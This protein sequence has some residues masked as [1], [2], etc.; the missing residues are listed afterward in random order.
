MADTSSNR[1]S[2]APIAEDDPFAELTRIMGFDPRVKVH[3]PQQPVEPDFGL[4]LERELLGE[5]HGDQDNEPASM[6][7][8]A[9]EAP[10]Q[11]PVFAQS[12]AAAPAVEPADDLQDHAS[13]AAIQAYQTDDETVDFRQAAD[14]FVAEPEQ[15]AVEPDVDPFADFELSFDE[16]ETIST[17]DMLHQ[18]SEP[19]PVEAVEVSA[20]SQAPAEEDDEIEAAYAALQAWQ[21]D[22]DQQ[23]ADHSQAESIESEAVESE[24]EAVSVAEPQLEAV[25]D[26]QAVEPVAD[27]PAEAF[28]SLDLQ[29]A[30]ELAR[31]AD[32]PGS[33]D[34]ASFEDEPSAA[35]TQPALI[36]EH[37]AGVVE[38]QSESDPLGDF[39]LNGWD[40]AQ[41]DASP[42]RDVFTAEEGWLDE[43]SVALDEPQVLAQND[44]DTAPSDAQYAAPQSEQWALVEAE[45]EQEQQATPA[46]DEAFERE[47]F[48]L[49]GGEMDSQQDAQSA[50]APEDD[51]WLEGIDFADADAQDEAQGI[52]A[53]AAQGANAENDDAL[54]HLDFSEV[55]TAPAAAANAAPVSYAA[56]NAEPEVPSEDTTAEP[57]LGD[58]EMAELLDDDAV[59]RDIEAAMEA[60]TAQPPAPAAASVAALSA[61][62][63]VSAAA[64]SSPYTETRTGTDRAP[65]TQA[66][67]NT[68]STT[69]P[70]PVEESA[71][72]DMEPEAM[73]PFDERAFD[74][75]LADELAA[76]PYGRDDDHNTGYRQHASASYGYASQARPMVNAPSMRADVPDIET[77]DF[78]D[79]RLAHSDELDLPEVDYG[80][81]PA[82]RANGFD[83]F[84]SQ[85]ESS[86]H[87]LNAEPAGQARREEQEAQRQA[88]TQ[89]WDEHLDFSM[90]AAAAGAAAGASAGR[91]ESDLSRAGMY[92]PEDDDNYYEQSARSQPRQGILGRRG[93]LMAGAVAAIVLIGG[94]AILA[95]PGGSVGSGGEPTLVRAD[96]DPMK[97]R[98]ENPGGTTV[99]NQDNVVYDRV[100]S[101]QPLGAPTQ[102]RLISED[103][104]PVDLAAQEADEDS[105]ASLSALDPEGTDPEGADV[106]DVDEEAVGTAGKAEDRLTPD[107]TG[108]QQVPEEMVAV[109][110]RR[111]RTMVVRPDGSL[112]PREEEAAAPAPQLASAAAA[113]TAEPA[114]V[115]PAAAPSLPEAD[116][117]ESVI[118]ETPAQP[119]PQA[120]PQ[121]AAVQPTAQSSAAPAAV[122]AAAA[123]SGWAVQI[124]SQ[125]SE[126][127][128][129][130]SYDNLSRR[131]ASVLSGK[132]VNIVRADIAGKGTYYRVRVAA[133]SR[134][135]ANTICA[136]YKSAGGSCFVSQ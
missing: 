104:A 65:S 6:S 18:G 130:A 69:V 2:A 29:L 131:Y 54:W 79:Q 128:A 16:D 33:D 125:P 68:V 86:F 52:D 82:P 45:A 85:F 97:V 4:D 136:S 105:M 89:N 126:A 73:Q 57:D 7:Q 78:V 106:G 119:A 135:E 110:P 22:R 80:R 35:E 28:D 24:P 94:V 12:E 56:L 72:L 118:D 120:A 116:P 115:A 101:G 23:A 62:A 124:A 48:D 92:E 20:S 111:V 64:A 75:A 70:D 61:A 93:M 9:V 100:G 44:H 67:T 36:V 90:G 13:A 87:S 117:I 83:D 39:D 27:E 123:P 84:D 66:H 8:R 121:V 5:F 60:E 17:S 112:A 43:G 71:Q 51:S 91:Y 76:D 38:A 53:P 21:D 1:A 41:A 103:A 3:Q 49:L 30:E 40:D 108:N 59:A 26:V 129:Q 134:A 74:A 114:A 132:N 109:A 14:A 37:T 19:Q 46:H 113:V 15:S 99:P 31:E 10:R 127:A 107:T 55:D 42:E 58:F 81:E 50:S 88:S 96:A 98:P 102:E 34:V 63:A 133:S 11:E 77:V 122:E 25:D 32:A 95:M 47:L